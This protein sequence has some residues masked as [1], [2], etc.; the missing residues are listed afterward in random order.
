MLPSQYVW[1][2]MAPVTEIN[3]VEQIQSRVLKAVEG[4]Q[5]PTPAKENMPTITRSFDVV[6]RKV[7]GT[8]IKPAA[9]KDRGQAQNLKLLVYAEISV[10]YICLRG[11]RFGSSSVAKISPN[12]WDPFSCE[13]PC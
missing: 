5:T 8:V 12:W 13:R 9:I 11:N 2:S 10:G 7:H 4:M 1:Y 6:G 3:T